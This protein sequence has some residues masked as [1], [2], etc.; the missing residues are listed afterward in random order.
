MLNEKQASI[1]LDILVQHLSLLHG[2]FFCIFAQLFQF[3]LE[4]RRMLLIDLLQSGQK[5]NR[6]W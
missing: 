5:N 2:N 3:F 6:I 4:A 1:N